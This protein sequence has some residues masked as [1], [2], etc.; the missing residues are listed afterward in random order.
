VRL[1]IDLG[2]TR[3]KW[4]W[5]GD[6]RVQ[7]GGA[8]DS[9]GDLLKVPEAL[10]RQAGGPPEQIG[11]AA[12]ARAPQTPELLHRLQR[13]LGTVPTLLTTTPRCG[14]VICGYDHPS[15]LGV[16]RW[17]AVIGAWRRAPGR[18]A[19]VVDAGSALTMDILA[20][21][22]RHLGGSI[23]PGLALARA[24]FYSRTGRTEQAGQAD[25][26]GF[27][28]NTGDAVASGTLLGMAGAVEAVWR[29]YASSVPQP[30]LWVT[31]GDANELSGALDVAHDVVPDLVFEGMDVML[32]GAE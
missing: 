17:A 11:V 8:A 2:H 30:L 7:R 3:L 28:R 27:A 22:G 21:D 1:L 31:G 15:S 13:L 18:A 16:D 9:H 26:A 32:G 14:R 20:A 25:R 29:R 19:V 4:A 10:A 6:G 24:A 5:A 12:V 23:A